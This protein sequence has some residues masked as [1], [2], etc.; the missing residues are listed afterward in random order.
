MDNNPVKLVTLGGECF[1]V[2]FQR[3]ATAQD[4]DGVFY[5]FKLTDLVKNRGE[6]LVS[7]VRFGPKETYGASYDTRLDTV[8][9]NVLRRAID[10]GVVSFELPHEGHEYQKLTLNAADFQPR[11]AVGD[12]D[13]R[14]FIIHK[15]FWLA[16][17]HS[18][19]GNRWP[20]QFDEPNELEYLGVGSEDVKRIV[21][22]LGQQGL[23]EKT[24]IPGLG[25]PTARLVEIYEEKHRMALPNK[26][27]FPKRTKSTAIGV[28]A[29]QQQE[30]KHEW[31]V[32]VS[33]ANED[34][35][36]I[37]RSLALA[38]QARGLRV[39][40][41]EFSLT[42]GDSL[43]ESIDHGLARSEF[44]VVILS[45]HFFEKHWP[46]QE[47]NG[48]A[49]REVKGKKVILPVWHGVSFE[50]VRQ[51]SPMLADRLAVTTEKGV[52]HVVEQ[53]LGAM[54]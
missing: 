27:L 10:S 4:S 29:E 25:R 1:E 19:G 41:D 8:L 28:Q 21:W 43:R 15:A 12:P 11:P 2:L 53:L 20:V 5:L 17:R 38:L 39:W 40:Y 42:V 22:L 47:L 34:K 13:L 33:H 26:T 48:L 31:D 9:L 24:N 51:Y 23:L 30:D 37:A 14:Q 7:V 45:G 54:K 18:P 6:R 52:D 46:T 35:D 16:Y 32:F 44:G 3:Q 36:A 49:T 50:E